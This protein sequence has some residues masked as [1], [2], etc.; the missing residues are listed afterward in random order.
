[1][2]L[3]AFVPKADDDA[4]DPGLRTMMRRLWLAAIVTFLLLL[5]AMH[6]L[7]NARLFADARVDMQAVASAVDAL[8][9]QGRTGMVLS[10]GVLSPW[11]GIVPS[12]MVASAAMAAS[13]ISVI[14]NALRLR[15]VDLGGLQ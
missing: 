10:A 11:L 6:C 3:G 13:S 1:M 4:V 5:M 7:G 15:S 8:R 9:Q 14:A 2:G 12:P